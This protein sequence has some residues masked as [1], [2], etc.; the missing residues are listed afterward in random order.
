MLNEL[1]KGL[2]DHAV[3]LIAAAV[4][5][6]LGSGAVA[7]YD[8][9]KNFMSFQTE[10]MSQLANIRDDVDSLRRP[11]EVFE[12]AASSRPEKGYCV[13]NEPCT[14]IIKARRTPQGIDCRI[15]P[16]EVKHYFFDP[17][18]DQKVEVERL[19]ASPSGV[20][21]LDWRLSEMIVT[22]PDIFPRDSQYYFIPFFNQCNGVGDTVAVSQSS[23][24]IETPLFDSDL[25][26]HENG[27]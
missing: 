1:T 18:T 20:L 23:K 19:N 2:K 27:Y 13:R 12:I 15:I 11:T 5:A 26:A 10:V 21:G 8:Y 6:S 22:A 14:F 24:I 9:G 7:V 17:K 25:E 3:K 4:L 16:G